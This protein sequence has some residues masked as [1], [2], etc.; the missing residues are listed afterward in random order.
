MT[1]EERLE[2]FK[3]LNSYTSQIEDKIVFDVTD[4]GKEKHY[5]KQGFYD[6]I[7]EEQEEEELDI[8]DDI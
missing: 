3:Q 4:Y 1:A 8:T 6:D 7:V 5:I 2:Q